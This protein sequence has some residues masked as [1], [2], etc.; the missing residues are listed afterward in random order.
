MRRL[1]DDRCLQLMKPIAF[2]INGARAEIV[3]AA[4]LCRA[5]I[6]GQLAG[7]AIEVRIATRL[8]KSLRGR[9]RNH[10]MKLSNV[11]MTPH[12]SD[13]TEGMLNGCANLIAQNIKRTALREI[14]LNVIAPES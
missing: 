2:L 10:F 3:D 7:A 5:V 11:L 12:V 9:L 1:I 14:P 6:S 4:A 13:W 8:Q